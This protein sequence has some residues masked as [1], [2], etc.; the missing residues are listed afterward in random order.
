MATAKKDTV[1]CTV[2]R[3]RDG[4]ISAS[5]RY[6]LSGLVG[7]SPEALRADAISALPTPGLTHAT[8]TGLSVD[9]V[10]VQLLD[11]D[12]AEAEVTYTVAPENEQSGDELI[13]RVGTTLSQGQ[14]NIDQNGDAMIVTYEDPQGK[15]FDQSGIVSAMLPQ[16]QVRRD[17]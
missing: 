5:D 9:K 10:A 15:E 2:E 13:I 7:A 6:V 14:I 1:N 16:T 4:Y 8:F 3:G 11:D 17:Y 12:K